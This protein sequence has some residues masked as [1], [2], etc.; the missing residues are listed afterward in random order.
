MT[1]TEQRFN[2]FIEAAQE[3]GWSKQVEQDG[4]L[5]FVTLSG[6]TGTILLT[7]CRPDRPG[8]KLSLSVRSWLRLPGAEVTS[9]HVA[10]WV[11]LKH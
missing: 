11:M 9:S 6:E 2:E 4:C 10:A 3:R 7:L 5:T 8:R 1:T